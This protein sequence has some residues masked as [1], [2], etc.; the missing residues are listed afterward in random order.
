MIRST[1]LLRMAP[2]LALSFLPACNRNRSATT[3]GPAELPAGASANEARRLQ[4]LYERAVFC[5]DYSAASTALLGLIDQ[6]PDQ[7]V[8][9]MEEVAKVYYTDHRYEACSEV[10][11]DLVAHYGSGRKNEVLEIQ[12]ICHEALGRKPEAIET[13]LQVMRQGGKPVNAVRLAGLLLEAERIPEAEGWIQSALASPELTKP[14]QVVQLPAAADRIQNIPAEA[15][16]RNLLGLIAMKRQ[17]ADPT[18]ARAAFERALQLAP[19]YVIAR[20]NLEAVT[21]ASTSAATANP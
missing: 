7:K 11:A 18:G 19:D 9:W 21:G 8:R 5:K 15:A 16:L 3:T 1:H 12:A 20:R 4:A 17:P 6:D 14:D 13:W 10:C 2:L